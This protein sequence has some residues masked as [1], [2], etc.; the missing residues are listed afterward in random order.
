MNSF[1]AAPG[2][3][4]VVPVTT[5]YRCPASAH[6]LPRRKLLLDRTGLRPARDDG[7]ETIARGECRA[8]LCGIWS[9]LSLQDEH[10]LVLAA[11]R[12]GTEQRAVSICRSGA[13]FCCVPYCASGPDSPTGHARIRLRFALNQGRRCTLRAA[14]EKLPRKQSNLRCYELARPVPGRH[15]THVS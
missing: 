10:R 3:L 5:L 13:F 6:C 7:A 11:C 8:A 12:A 4:G 15:T 1:C 2:R 9:V 14:N